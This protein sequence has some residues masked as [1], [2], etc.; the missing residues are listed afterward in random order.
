MEYMQQWSFRGIQFT[1]LFLFFSPRLSLDLGLKCPGGAMQ[2]NTG[3][4]DEGTVEP[5]E[6]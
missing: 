4:M 3:D 5:V 1:S 2:V 6:K